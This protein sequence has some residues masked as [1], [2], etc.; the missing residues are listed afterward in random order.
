[1]KPKNIKEK[2]KKEIRFIYKRMHLIWEKQ[3]ALGYYKLEKPIRHGWYKE[4]IITNNIE[5]YKNKKAILEIYKKLEKEVWAK[6]KEKAN[7]KWTNK[8][9]EYLIY[10]DL[11]TLSKKQ[12]N[13]LSLQA[14]K[15]CIPYQFRNENK[16]LKTR[17]YIKIPKATY[18]IRF[19]RAFI[20]HRKRIDSKLEEAIALL[21]NQ[22]DKEGYYE[23]NITYCNWKNDWNLKPRESRNQ[24]KNISKSSIEDLLKDNISWE[25][26]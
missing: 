9:S 10:R 16:K 19:K 15:I 23:K 25:K 13:K 5:R 21:R 14:K 22:L 4:L 6:T 26:N 3:Q 1:M 2:R 8:I 20:T 7:K 12:F 17:F 24:L 18:R 11:P